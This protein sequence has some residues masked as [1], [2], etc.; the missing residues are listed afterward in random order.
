MTKRIRA[1]VFYL[2]VLVFFILG[3]SAVLYAQGWRLQF[4]PLVF[5]KIGGIY[6]H[7]S[8]ED[9]EV[10]VNGKLAN[11]SM[12]LFERG[13]LLDN[14]FP[15]TYEIT[16]KKTGYL[17]WS[18]NLPVEPS[19]VTSRNKIVLIPSP[20]EAVTSTPV[21]T[22]QEF[23]NH[24]AIISQNGRIHFGGTAVPGDTVLAGTDDG[25]R[26]ITMASR[27]G[28]YF[29]TDL[30]TGTSTVLGRAFPR[31]GLSASTQV[32]VLSIPQ[33][34]LTFLVQS[35]SY[36]RMANMATGK[37][38]PLE[39]AAPISAVAP[40]SDR[41]AWTV[42]RAKD[43]R[44]AI[45]T[46]DMLSGTFSRNADFVPG[47]TIQIAFL[48]RDSLLLLQDNGALYSL[49]LASSDR[50]KIADR[51]SRFSLA[52]DG[53]EVAVLQEEGVGIISES[54]PQSYMFFRLQDTATIKDIVWYKDGGHLFIIYPQKTSFLDFGD[55]SLNN[56]ATVAESGNVEYA[57]DQNALYAVTDG[58]L[59]RFSFP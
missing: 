53:T 44:S 47:K 46:Y 40:S 57:A 1:Y 13:R 24:L 10:Y 14:L 27:T 59:M 4:T 51:V 30:L 16:I 43:G 41:I 33:N 54:D 6:L 29:W 36:L 5:D 21:K 7:T 20:G 25:E 15:G 2:L 58:S 23:G 39:E 55:L 37:I 49:S 12:R 42:W 48:N 19:F 11:V 8:P 26:V 34:G 56:F 31:L 17:D 45:S 3:G 9:A 38:V 22:V 32:T 18:S 35:S 50:K 52:P 28:A